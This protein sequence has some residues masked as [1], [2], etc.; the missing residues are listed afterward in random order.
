MEVITLKTICPNC[1]DNEV[2]VHEG[3]KIATC[4]RCGYRFTDELD[5]SN[6]SKTSAERWLEKNGYT[7]DGINWTEIADLM[8]RYHREISVQ[9]EYNPVMDFAK[10]I[11]RLEN[12]IEAIGMR[13]VGA[14]MEVQ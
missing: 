10:Y 14:T 11:E 4:V 2:I 7:G 1:F 3:G 12:R 5:V 13:G 9:K 6:K 8:E